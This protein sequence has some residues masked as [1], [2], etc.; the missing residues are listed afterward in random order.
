MMHLSQ[1]RNAQMPSASPANLTGVP[2]NATP[3]DILFVLNAFGGTYP[4]NTVYP[5]FSQGG[6]PLSISNLLLTIRIV[7]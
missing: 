5:T 3:H 2:S 6:Y 4:R 1:W 7:S